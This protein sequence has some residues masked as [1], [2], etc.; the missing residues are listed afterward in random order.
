MRIRPNCLD[1]E[2]K[3]VEA[4]EIEAN[5]DGEAVRQAQSLKGCRQCEV[6]RGHNLVAKLSEFSDNPRNPPAGETIPDTP[7]K[8]R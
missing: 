2:G 5:S 6:S 7:R 3:S 4:K 1:H 8:F